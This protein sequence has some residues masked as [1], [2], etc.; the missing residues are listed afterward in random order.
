MK[1]IRGLHNLRA[2]HCGGVATI[3]NFDG[4]HLGHQSVIKKLVKLAADKQ[5]HS[6]LIT[7]EPLP[8]ELFMGDKSPARLSTLR[9]KIQ[10]LESMGIDQC[11][12]L[13]FN[14]KL[15][16]MEAACF[17]KTVLHKGLD[18]QLLVVGDDFRFGKN[19]SGDYVLLQQ[20]GKQAGFEVLNTETFSDNSIRVSS[21]V[22]REA[23]A[24]GDFA[25]ATALLGREFSMS[26]K[27]IHGDKRGRLLGFPTA[28]ISVNRRVSPLHG[29]FAVELDG[30][31]LKKQAGVANIGNRPTIGGKGF[32]IEVHCLDFSAD[33]YGK[34]LNVTMKNKIRDEKKFD[35][36]ED[37]TRQI[38]KDKQVAQQY[39]TAYKM[40]TTNKL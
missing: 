18:I 19:R 7:F 35:S 10:M 21:T 16:S 11:L 28:N 27:V 32:L 39:F 2:E 13:P 4:L 33:L 37:L 40:E 12:C 1:I 30:C 17:A 8:H 20:F 22:I 5:T 36:L 38:A 9:D 24:R 26:G 14:A 6:T 15:S 23:L 34:R 31:G 29:V 25:R 3:G